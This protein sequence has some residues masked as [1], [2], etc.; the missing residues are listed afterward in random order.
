MNHNYLRRI[1][2]TSGRASRRRRTH[3]VIMGVLWL[4]DRLFHSS[5]NGVDIHVKRKY[6]EFA[7][8]KKVWE[9]CSR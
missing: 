4:R 8:L 7:V 1:W 6:E 3:Q 9:V 5:E 2:F